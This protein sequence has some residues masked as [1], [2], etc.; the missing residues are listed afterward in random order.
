MA[1]AKRLLGEPSGPALPPIRK[2]THPS[3]QRAGAAQRSPR[4]PASA[5]GCVC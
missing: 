4:L 1:Q 3:E 5:S 2:T